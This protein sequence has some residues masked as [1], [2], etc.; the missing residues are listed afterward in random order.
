MYS[1]SHSRVVLRS[2]RSLIRT[3]LWCCATLPTT[4]TWS[5]YSPNHDFSGQVWWLVV[6]HCGHSLIRSSSPLRSAAPFHAAR[7]ADTPTSKRG[8]PTKYCS[9][10]CRDEAGK[11]QNVRHSQ[12]WRDRTFGHS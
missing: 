7:P 3:A 4:G 12:E 9:D 6:P 10:E 1:A 11:D 5:Y 2:P 8:A